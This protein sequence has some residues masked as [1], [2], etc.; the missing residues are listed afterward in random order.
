MLPLSRL[1]KNEHKDAFWVL[2]E[3][4]SFVCLVYI[5]HLHVLHRCA[6]VAMCVQYGDAGG[7]GGVGLPIIVYLIFRGRVLP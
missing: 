1:A 7:L 6:G 3:G 2:K 4:R 5:M